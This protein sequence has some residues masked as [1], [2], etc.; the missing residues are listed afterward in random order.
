MFSLKHLEI[1]GVML[2][3][4]CLLTG[5]TFAFF[6]LY[7]YRPMESLAVSLD[8]TEACPGAE[9]PVTVSYYLEPELFDGVRSLEVESNWRAENVPGKEEGA[10]VLAADAS[11]PVELLNEGWRRGESR[12]TRR[13][14]GEPG[15]WQLD[16]ETTLRGSLFYLPK[17]QTSR[18]TSAKSL[19][20]TA[21]ADCDSFTERTP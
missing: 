7:P 8:E 5:L 4:G 14:P 21:S 15:V 1:L 18:V 3:A 12:V 9:V 6:V 20:V 2:M 13:A 17:F 19:T 10:V 11:I 16:T